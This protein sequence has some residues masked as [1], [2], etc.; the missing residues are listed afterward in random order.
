MSYPWIKDGQYVTPA[1]TNYLA[2]TSPNGLYLTDGVSPATIIT[3][4]SV[5]ATT[6][7]G[8][9]NGTVTNATNATNVAIT[10]DN[11]NATF[12]PVFVSNNTGNL[13][14]KVDK[15]TTPFSYVPSTGMLTTTQ[16]T[17]T[18][19]YG[20]NQQFYSNTSDTLPL[21]LVSLGANYEQK[22]FYITPQT[23]LITYFTTQAE[24]YNGAGYAQLQLTSGN[25]T[26]TAP[27]V[28]LQAF[29]DY[30]A[31]PAYTSNVNK[32]TLGEDTVSG[33][34]GS[35]IVL[36]NG[37]PAFELTE[38]KIVLHTD[39]NYLNNFIRLRSAFEYTG[40]ESYLTLGIQSFDLTIA[41]QLALTIASGATDP[42]VFRRNISTTTNTASG[43]PVGLLE[44]SRNDTF[45]TTLTTNLT[46]SEAFSTTIN[47]PTDT[48]RAY[49]LPS[50]SG[51]TI[52]YW[53]GI[54]NKSTLF[55][56]AVKNSSGTTIAT[57]PVAPVSGGSS[58]VRFAV[59]AGG[60]SYFAVA[61]SSNSTNATNVAITDDNTNATFYPVF[62]SNN[63][64]NLPLKVDKTTGPLSYNPSTG[65]LV[66]PSFSPGSG[67]SIFSA[68]TVDGLEVLS[69]T[70]GRTK[71]LNNQ[72][73]C[74]TT[75]TGIP[76]T[77]TINP[78]SIT[79]SSL[80]NLSTTT[81]TPTSVTATTFNGAL[82]GT[83]TNA[84]N[85]AI[86]EDNT[87]AT[88][89]PVF[90]SDNTGNLPLKVDKTTN[91][92]SYNPS[93]G[94]MVNQIYFAGTSASTTVLSQLQS[95][96]LQ[97]V[98]AGSNTT[99]INSNQ[100]TCSQVSGSLT[101]TI[102]P[103]SVTTT[104]FNG[105]LNGNAST[106]TR[107][108]N[109]AGGLG[110]QIPYQTAVNTT[111]LLAN[112]TAGQY[113]KSNGT[114]LAP[115]WVNQNTAATPSG[116]TTSFSGSGSDTLTINFNNSFSCVTRY[117]ITAT[118]NNGTVIRTI[119]NYAL[120]GGVTGG[121]YTVVVEI[122]MLGNAGTTFT[123]NGTGLTTAPVPKTNF[124]TISASF[125]GTTTTRHFVLT[126]AY[127]GTNYFLSGSLFN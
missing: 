79:C 8:T 72:I 104:T 88:F 58:V 59:G 109:I 27:K 6:F 28:V 49:Q 47:T 34:V 23:A 101:T 19:S 2:V 53:Y 11:T 83:A 118:N 36:T 73:T 92:L 111:A 48:T 107:A 67:N 116:I 110:G 4:T 124:T 69:A 123:F 25:L 63:T 20:A 14:L 57:V 41:Q 112:G 85:V 10:D 31:A 56:I 119:T 52:G 103:T 93:T 97:V 102:T 21:R 3:P 70:S 37:N 74:A 66:C 126:F 39:G 12:Y 26:T 33:G 22:G 50:A 81:I 98:N 76:P 77:T 60:T 95:T 62:V 65:T 13:P 18:G 78:S 61:D 68:L 43:N 91:P 117:A 64:G 7:Y 87:S 94:T 100:I 44:N 5:T 113:L 114:T 45:V 51:S 96:G 99:T 122:T 42:I 86:T 84:T 38:N 15:T 115:S 17:T 16:F 46:V 90:V 89:Y 71:I 105:A 54:C 82:N 55:T 106:A 121:Q 29:V 40:L 120:S 108:T 75:A 1:A 9:L 35:D 80:N 127:D 125:G 24:M 30:D 32:L